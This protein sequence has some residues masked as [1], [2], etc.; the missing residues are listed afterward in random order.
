MKIIIDIDGV[1]SEKLVWSI[2]DSY[3][4]LR[5]MLLEI[6]PNLKVINKINQL[7][8]EG[9]IIIL[10]T[11]R[12]WHDYE[13]TITWLRKHGVEYDELI[14]AKPLGDAYIDNKNMSIKEFLK[15]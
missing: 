2:G 7:H 3:L 13:P 12:L 4:R 15:L 11:G 9:H 5:E 6:E 8:S 10:F 1:L 14:M